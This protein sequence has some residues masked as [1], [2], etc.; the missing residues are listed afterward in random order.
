MH[1]YIGSCSRSLQISLAPTYAEVYG[2][3]GD[4]ATI[5][6]CVLCCHRH[7]YIFL[8]SCSLLKNIYSYCLVGL[9]A[10]QLA[11]NCSQWGLQIIIHYSKNKMASNGEP[12]LYNLKHPEVP[13]SRFC[14]TKIQLPGATTAMN[15]CIACFVVIATVVIY[16]AS[17]EEVKREKKKPY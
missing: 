17:L 1:L 15:F 9:P 13:Q 3:V 10:Q 12:M 11:D 2:Y 5:L 7:P 16:S 4:G 8:I 6:V 14:F